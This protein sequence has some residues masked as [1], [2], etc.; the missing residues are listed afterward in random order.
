MQSGLATRQLLWLPFY[1]FKK[2]YYQSTL[3]TLIRL[4][5]FVF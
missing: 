4:L 1:F 2:H 5:P 3:T